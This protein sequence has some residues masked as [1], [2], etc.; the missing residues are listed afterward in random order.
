MYATECEKYYSKGISVIPSDGKKVIISSFGQYSFRGP[1]RNEVNFF[2]KRY[3]NNNVGLML[4]PVNN[5][6]AIDVDTDLKGVLSVVENEAP[7]TPCAKF[8][9]KGITKFYKGV[10][11]KNNMFITRKH[12]CMLEFLCSSK[13]TIVPP[14]I[15][16]ETNAPYR[17]VGS[18]V[19]DA[20]DD[21][22]EIKPQHLQAIEHYMR[23]IGCEDLDEIRMKNNYD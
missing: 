8:G 10:R 3:A 7:K 2:K 6:I 13:Y 1:K 16:P 22:P 19:L 5:L 21:I 11:P 14:S 18:S 17:W 15:H 4:G 12:G 9:K 23:S 20:Y